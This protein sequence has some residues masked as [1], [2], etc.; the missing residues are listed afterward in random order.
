MTQEQVRRMFLK[1]NPGVKRFGKKGLWYRCAHCGKWCGRSGPD[2]VNIPANERMEVDHIQS[3]SNGGSDA[4][5]NLQPLCM[6][7]NR[8]KSATPNFQDNIKIIGNAILHPVDT[9]VK[10]PI[11]K[12]VRQND[13]L[14]SLGIGKRK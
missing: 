3:W 9:L 5:S 4:L 11:R 12:A 10:T 2:H 1:A 8:S 14:K 7:C 6:P 13:V